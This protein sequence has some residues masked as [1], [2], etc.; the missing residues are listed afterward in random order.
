M[1]SV[2][3]TF[4][5]L[6]GEAPSTED[7]C[8]DVIACWYKNGQVETHR[9]HTIRDADRVRFVVWIPDEAALEE[10]HHN[11]H[12][13]RALAALTKAGYGQPVARVLG[14]DRGFKKPCDCR[15]RTS[16]VLFTNYCSIATPLRCGDCFHPVPVY[17]L[18]H[19]RDEEHLDLLQWANDY[20][21]CDT[22]Q[23]HCT[24]G[25]EFGEAELFRHDSSLSRTGRAL[26]AD[27]TAKVG[28]PVYYFL[29]A[30]RGTGEEAER[31]RVCPSCGG[32]WLVEP[33]WHRIFDFRCDRCLLLSNI[34]SDLAEA[35]V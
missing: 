23:M 15:A 30:S 35:A 24:T 13:R 9:W 3:L 34:A 6:P 29:F 25:E 18:P 2:E 27:L 12:A 16:L 5:I 28:V 8:E 14:I 11:I 32:N 31:A 7:A 19:I 26:A 10:P 20:R 1:L 4:P 33:P 21:A 17:R 22:L